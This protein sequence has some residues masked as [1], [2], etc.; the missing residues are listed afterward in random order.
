MSVFACMILFRRGARV[1]WPT[2]NSG[3]D[4]ST[5]A[6]QAVSIHAGDYCVRTGDVGRADPTWPKHDFH[7]PL[8]RGSLLCGHEV[9]LMSSVSEIM[10]RVATM[11]PMAHSIDSVS[12]CLKSCCMEQPRS[13]GAPSLLRG[14]F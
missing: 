13:I 6:K 3:C 8:R 14:C 7:F 4:Q 5:A 9:F 1:T 12:R 2:C 10:R 11:L